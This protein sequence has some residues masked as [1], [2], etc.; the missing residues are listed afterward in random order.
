MARDSRAGGVPRWQRRRGS[1]GIS[2]RSTRPE[3]VE[4]LRKSGKTAGQISGDLGLTETS[5]RAWVRQ[6]EIDEGK[7][8][9]GALT[10]A[11]RE[12]FTAMK[13]EL[14]TLRLERDI[15][16]KTPSSRRRAREVCVH[17]GGEG[18][19]TSEHAS[20][21]RR[22]SGTS[23]AFRPR[24]RRTRSRRPRRA[25]VLSV[26]AVSVDWPPRGGEAVSA[27][28]GASRSARGDARGRR[29]CDGPRGPG[30][31]GS[32]GSRIGGTWWRGPAWCCERACLG[33]PA[34]THT[35]GRSE[36]LGRGGTPSGATGPGRARR[37]PGGAA[38]APSP[39]FCGHLL[40]DR[41]LELRLGKR[42]LERPF[43]VSRARSFL[44]SAMSMPPNL[45]L[46]A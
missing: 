25:Q 3:V 19:G 26:A 34:S 28:P 24:T 46:H 27:V 10:S 22:P 39:F 20:T 8:P 43:S 44:A 16:K 14:K 18:L 13:R 17:L 42:L 36:R 7:G 9:A 15:L 41:I 45:R 23:A 11:E 12:E 29:S 31:S 4:L 40:E 33:R 30:R 2:R 5:V 32:G 35:R 21:R 6:A 1:G 38:R 37:P